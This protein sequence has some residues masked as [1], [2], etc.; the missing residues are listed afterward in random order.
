M[1]SH[2]VSS[3][4]ISFSRYLLCT[5]CTKHKQKTLPC[6]HFTCHGL[7]PGP[8]S[9]LASEQRFVSTV[10]SAMG[11]SVFC[12]SKPF[13]QEAFKGEIQCT[14]LPNQIC[15][16]TNHNMFHEA[17]IQ[18][19]MLSSNQNIVVHRKGNSNVNFTLSHF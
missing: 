13:M 3:I 15:F 7:S 14:I 4:I 17:E 12:H 6:T 18:L 10:L 5:T 2:R 16:L 9:C 8:G 19:L 11:A 1:R